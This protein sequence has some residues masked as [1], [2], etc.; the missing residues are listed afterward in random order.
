M[1]TVVNTS[2]NSNDTS[3]VDTSEGSVPTNVI[4]PVVALPNIDKMMNTKIS[5]AKM[6][7]RASRGRLGTWIDDR[8]DTG[9]EP[10]DEEASTEGMVDPQEDVGEAEATNVKNAEIGVEMLPYKFYDESKIGWCMFGNG[11]KGLLDCAVGM[12]QWMVDERGLTKKIERKWVMARWLPPE[13]GDCFST[14]M[15]CTR[16]GE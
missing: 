14:P 10:R 9:G 12:A 13:G 4:P 6:A 15:L 11:D 2:T 7:S 1:N 3:N 5:K 8:E 16:A